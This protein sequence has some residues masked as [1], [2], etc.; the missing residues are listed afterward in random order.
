MSESIND[1]TISASEY[2]LGKSL[3]ESGDYEAA[4]SHFI[5]GAER[6]DADC[7]YA[8][9]DCYYNGQGVE[10][11]FTAAIDCYR[12]AA[13]QGHA[14][15]QNFFG[16]FNY[17]EQNY[18]EAVE[19]YRKAAESGLA[20][21]QYNLAKCYSDGHGVEQSDAEAVAWF[22]KAAEQGHNR[23]QYSLGKICYKEAVEWFRKAAE[24][25]HAEAKKM[26]K[27]LGE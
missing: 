24:Q 12:K 15:A 18:T 27:K 22:R 10:Q 6:Y 13:E 11:D 19:W 26:L 2:L 8:L 5:V 1:T 4:V 25:G 7:Q 3:F 9:G 21:A 20:Q 16:D 14:G 23:A 17:N